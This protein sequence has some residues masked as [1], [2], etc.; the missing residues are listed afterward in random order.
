MT[1]SRRKKKS[2]A[3][4]AAEEQLAAEGWDGAIAVAVA[5]PDRPPVVWLAAGGDLRR[6]ELAEPY[7]TE[8]VGAAPA[9][10]VGYHD[11]SLYL[12][13]RGRLD[14]SD[15]PWGEQV[16]VD[17]TVDTA[18]QW[19]GPIAFVETE[20]RFLKVLYLGVRD[21][22]YRVVISA[23]GAGNVGYERVPTRGLRSIRALAHYLSPHSGNCF[24]FAVSG[25][26]LYAAKVDPVE[27]TELRFVRVGAEGWGGEIAIHEGRIYLARGELM[28]AVIPDS[29]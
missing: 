4:I 22:L 26:A 6:G 13:S 29:Y 27:I 12:A 8:V 15:D 7:D 11:G 21:A 9:G 20:K 24:L 3:P 18:L 17:A 2:Y 14:R 25:G 19:G 1:E 28:A 23:V 16:G 5:A 10:P